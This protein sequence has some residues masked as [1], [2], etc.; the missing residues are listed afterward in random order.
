[1]QNNEQETVP[2]TWTSPALRP[3]Q[4]AA[5][6]WRNAPR[7]PAA[8]PVAQS[9]KKLVGDERIAAATLAAIERREPPKPKPKPTGDAAIAEKTLAGI[10]AI[11]SKRKR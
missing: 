9:K 8:K 10:E 7:V 6:G 1:M 5:A 2:P 3:A 11:T 4:P